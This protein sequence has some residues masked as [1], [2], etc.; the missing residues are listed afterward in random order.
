VIVVTL[1][2]ANIIA[3]IIGLALAKPLAQLTF[4]KSS[5]LIPIIILLVVVGSYGVA[6]DIR[7]VGI[8]FLFGFVGFFM[9]TYDYS[10]ITFT[11][12]YVLGDYVERYFL[13]SLTSLGPAFL[14]NSPI[15]LILLIFTILGLTGG[16]F[17]NLIKK[18]LLRRQ[19]GA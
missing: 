1:I 14:L 6:N 16:G 10:R 11:I 3:G 13:I 18:I 9:K 5:I 19:E 17:K 12:G 8:A 7:D 15:A 4:V 2:V